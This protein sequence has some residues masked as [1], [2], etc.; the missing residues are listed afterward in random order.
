MVQQLLVVL[1]PVVL[2]PKKRLQPKKKKKLKKNQMVI[3]AWDCSTKLI[4][5]GNRKNHV[6]YVKYNSYNDA[7]VVIT[8]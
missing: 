7:W 5:N 8:I 4:S 2:L 6:I 3:W 1:L